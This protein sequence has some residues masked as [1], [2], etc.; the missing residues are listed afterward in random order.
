MSAQDYFKSLIK[1]IQ[2]LCYGSVANVRHARHE[3]A[4]AT[5]YN[6]SA[7]LIYQAVLIICIIYCVVI[8]YWC[9]SVHCVIIYCIVYDGVHNM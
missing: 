2:Y 8:V 1:V 4:S 9:Y 5:S 3:P 6:S 7:L